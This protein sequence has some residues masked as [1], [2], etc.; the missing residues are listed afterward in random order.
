MNKHNSPT[1]KRPT[2]KEREKKSNFISLLL[3]IL[4]LQRP[5]VEEFNLNMIIK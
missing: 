4:T 1:R 3:P 5:R 2:F